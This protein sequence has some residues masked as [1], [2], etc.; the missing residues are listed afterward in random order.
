MFDER[1]EPGYVLRHVLGTT[2]FVV[3]DGDATA[4]PGDRIKRRDVAHEDPRSTVRAQFGDERIESRSIVLGRDPLAEVV[5]REPD[6]HEVRL[7]QVVATNDIVD[8]YRDG[9]TRPCGHREDRRPREC[10]AV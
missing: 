10:L 7:L 2:C 4:D 3:V 1:V 8:G 5:D 9:R 6:R